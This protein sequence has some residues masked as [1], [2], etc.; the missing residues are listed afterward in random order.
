MGG[1]NGTKNT[2]VYVTLSGL[3]LHIRLD[4]PYHKSTSGADFWTLHAEVRPVGKEIHALVA[5]NL[6]ATLWEVLPSLEPKDAESP[7]LNAL[8]KEF[9][10]FQVE[11][12]KSAK[13]V[14]VA[15]SSRHFNI[16]RG[17]WTFHKA[18]AD[19]VAEF[20]LRRVYW[21]TKVNGPAPVPVADATDAQYLGASTEV[22]LEAAKKIAAQGVFTLEGNYAR[23]TEGLMGHG[24][25]FEAAQEL[26][27]EHLEKKHAFERG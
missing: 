23:A 13:L 9:D 5:I 8:R 16:K 6:T 27:L 14:P 11:F 3:A 10:R 7:T 18:N 21:Q 20:L 12:M 4:W 2:D 17:E 19:Q 15:F 25:A 24:S 22:L 1:E 26:A